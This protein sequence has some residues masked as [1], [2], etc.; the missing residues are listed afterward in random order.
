[1]YLLDSQLR[2]QKKKRAQKHRNKRGLFTL[3]SCKRENQAFVLNV[4]VFTGLRP[5]RLNVNR[6][7]PDDLD[8]PIH[9]LIF[10]FPV[11]FQSHF[12]RYRGI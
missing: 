6:H 8:S 2:I 11:V 9:P 5:A 1:M 3:L 12:T 4:Y 7:R 10:F